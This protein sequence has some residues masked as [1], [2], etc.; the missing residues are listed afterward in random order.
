MKKMR[1]YILLP[2]IVFIFG[3]CQKEPTASFN[4]SK[5]TAEV[6]ETITF[7]NTS[8]NAHSFEWNFGDQNTSTLETPS[9]SYNV[10]NSY[11]VSLT[12]YSKN[13]K[14]KHTVSVL[15]EIIEAPET[16]ITDIDGNEYQI[17]T[18]GSQ[19]WMAENLKTTKFSNGVSITNITSNAQW[20]SASTPAYCWYNNNADN[21]NKWGGLYNWEAVNS[22]VL[23]PEGWHVPTDSEWAQLEIALGLPSNEAYTTGWRGT[24]QGSKMATNNSLW[25]AGSLTANN[26]FGTSG[27]N[28]L[29]AGRRNADGTFMLENE[30]AIWWTSTQNLSYNAYYRSL[31]YSDAKVGRQTFLN[32][33]GFSIRCLK[34]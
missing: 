34:N 10:A 2:L 12:A 24:D 6:G 31:I 1:F 15:I 13:E 14:K 4:A 9:H 7:N 30:F 18:I 26:Q 19:T 28:G 27:F 17:V 32:Q 33:H 25:L 8:L 22:G 20:S 3:S 29:P 16:T 11:L 5:T 23:C 21:K